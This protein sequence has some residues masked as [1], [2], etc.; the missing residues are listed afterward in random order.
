MT[1]DSTVF[2]VLKELVDQLRHSMEAQFAAIEATQQEMRRAI[3]SNESHVEGVSMLRE[4]VELQKA[5]EEKW[6]H[7]R[8]KIAGFLII[9][10]I[11]W[12]LF[13]LGWVGVKVLAYAN[14]HG[15]L[16]K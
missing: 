14:E 9:K 16:T 11:G 12:I 5:K 7:R 10:I 1:S 13:G 8:E 15:W 4:Y 6:R 2:V 3:Q